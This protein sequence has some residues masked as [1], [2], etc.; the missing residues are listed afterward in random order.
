MFS[1]SAPR[2]K[3]ASY[4]VTERLQRFRLSFERDESSGITST[5]LLRNPLGRKQPT[6]HT[7]CRDTGYPCT[8]VGR[9]QLPTFLAT[10]EQ[11]LR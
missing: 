1:D 11:T 7:L 5:C 3:M 8:L 10:Q 9:S 6:K 2:I 4:T